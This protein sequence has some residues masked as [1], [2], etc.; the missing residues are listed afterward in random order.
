MMNEYIYS[1]RNN[2]PYNKLLISHQLY[3]LFFIKKSSKQSN[4]EHLTMENLTME[5]LNLASHDAVVQ[6]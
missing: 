2:P 1:S 6:V 3:S 5:N 4:R